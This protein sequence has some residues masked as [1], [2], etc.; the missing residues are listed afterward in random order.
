MAIKY[1]L[2]GPLLISF[3]LMHTENFRTMGGFELLIP[4]G[5]TDCRPQ[6]ILFALC[7]KQLQ[8]DWEPGTP[9][10]S[11][12]QLSCYNFNSSATAQEEIITLLGGYTSYLNSKAIIAFQGG[13]AKKELSDS[14]VKIQSKWTE[15]LLWGKVTV[16]ELH[17]ETEQQPSLSRMN[18]SS[19]MGLLTTAFQVDFQI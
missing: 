6:P 12:S 11:L 16:L 5:S 19:M 4:S 7:Q 18:D 17:S 2:R 14:E 8:K 13:L 1:G 15:A 10:Q 3:Q 9:L